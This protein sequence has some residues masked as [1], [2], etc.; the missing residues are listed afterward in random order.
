MNC[1]QVFGADFIVD[2]N[3]KPH[4]IEMNSWPNM[5]N[6]FREYDEV[7]TEF[8]HHFYHD[9]AKPHLNHQPFDS[10]YFIRIYTDVGAA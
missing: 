6:P 9:L 8:F 1:F 10:E 4:V 7:L 3:L 5:N 2:N